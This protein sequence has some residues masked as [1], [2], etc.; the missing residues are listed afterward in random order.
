[1]AV[2]SMNDPHSGL[3]AWFA[4]NHVAANLLMVVIV[5]SGL[6]SAYYIRIQVNPDVESQSIQITVPYPGAS[7]GEVEIGVV[8]RV[9]AAV[10]HIDGIERM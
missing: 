7:P 5:I 1:M 3:I 10:R 6:V 4:R 2:S 8:D 9:E